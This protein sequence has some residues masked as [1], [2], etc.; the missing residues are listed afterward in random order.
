MLF[1][2]VDSAQYRLIAQRGSLDFSRD[3]DLHT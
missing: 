3:L 1:C 2:L